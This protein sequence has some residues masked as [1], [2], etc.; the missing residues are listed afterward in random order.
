MAFWRKLLKCMKNMKMK[1]SMADPCLYHRW[2]DNGLVLMA[3]WIDDNLIVG[4]NEVVVKTKNKLMGLFNCK[5]CIK[6]EKYVG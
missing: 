1:R 3:S 5:D 4:S 6:L 2:T